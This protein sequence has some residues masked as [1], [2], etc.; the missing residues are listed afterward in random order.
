M[1]SLR[2]ALIAA[3][4][5]AST[6]IAS[7]AD[8]KN[9]V[10]YQTLAAPQP[11]Q[12]TGKKVEVLEFFAYHC[13][14]CNMLEPTLKQWVKKQG[15]NI[16]MRRVPLP[17][18]GPADPEARLF[19]TLEAMG[20]LDQYHDRV[21]QAVH[22]QRQRLM[23]DDQIIE[24][25]VKNG[26]DKAKFMETWNSFGVTTKL[27]RLQQTASAYKVSG[28]PTIIIDG[29]YVVSPGQIQE[30]NKIQDVNQLMQATSQVLDKLVE[31]AAKTK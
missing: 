28:T 5:V 31:R 20:K 16:V 15:D 18:Q 24:W 1:R 11:V 12:A 7:P 14:A 6:A 9:G 25:A 10:D 4:M 19:L 27:R 17:F 8:P 26:L 30:S 3:T 23:K 29:K 2:F 22:V 21:F 13:P